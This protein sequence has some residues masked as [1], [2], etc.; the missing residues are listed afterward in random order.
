MSVETEE[1]RSE[2]VNNMNVYYELVRR[3]DLTRRARI[4]AS[5]RLR[6]KHDF[7]EKTSYFYSLIVL[8]L[9]I[10]FID[11]EGEITKVLL[12]SSLSLTFLTMFLGIKSYKER[13]GNFENNYQQL[14]VLLNKLQRLEACPEE[15]TQLKLKEL[16][17]DFEKLIIEKEN[18]ISIDYKRCKPEFEKKYMW[19]IS[20]YLFKEIFMRIVITV[21]PFLILVY[22]IMNSIT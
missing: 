7:F 19:D 11:G 3:V 6:N 16:H 5:D 14:N 4:K 18:H 10:W 15:I 17:R 21:A 12:I 9:S 1:T 8:I 13:A 2:S 20:F 22:F